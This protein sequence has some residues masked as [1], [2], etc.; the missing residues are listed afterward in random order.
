MAME[1]RDVLQVFRDS[2]NRS[3]EL[4][5]D[6]RHNPFYEEWTAEGRTKGRKEAALLLI[7][8][9]RITPKEAANL[10][11]FTAEELNALLTHTQSQKEGR[12]ERSTDAAL[13]LIRKMGISP[14]AAAELLD[15][16]AEELS[17][18]L[19]HI[20]SQNGNGRA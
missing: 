15:F 20:Q 14:E 9:M 4:W 19:I 2:H 8:K 10:L 11:D 7:L 17:A 12:T 16:T 5:E 1:E 3:R 6:L 18:L 13:A